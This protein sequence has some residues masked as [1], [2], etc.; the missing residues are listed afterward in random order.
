MVWAP[1]VATKARPA[2]VGP[3]PSSWV[4]NTADHVFPAS[5]T[6]V[7][8][9]AM[10][11]RAARNTGGR[12]S[13]A[14]AVGRPAGACSSTSGGPTDFPGGRVKRWA[15]NATTTHS[16]LEIVRCGPS[17]RPTVAAAVPMRPPV[18]APALHTAWKELMIE[19]PYPRWT[20]I[21]WL[22]CP[23][24][25]TESAAP[26]TNRPMRSIHSAGDQPTTTSAR[27]V[28]SVPSTVMFAAPNRRMSAAAASPEMIAPTGNVMTTSPNSVFVRSSPD[29]ISGY[30]GRRL[31]NSAP[32][33]KNSAAVAR[34]ALRMRREGAGRARDEKDTTLDSRSG[35]G[36]AERRRRTSLRLS[37]QGSPAPR[38]PRH[39]AARRAGRPAA[40]AWTGA[41]RCR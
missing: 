39:R 22:F 18:T 30:R 26:P 41:H 9:V 37:R 40:G 2:R 31:E 6:I 24:S 35:E 4:R 13:Q 10:R 16:A 21:P 1:T 32:L 15:T 14:A 29:L 28:S 34:R 19:R 27:A 25:V 12:M 38:P 17:G 3:A 8:L 20:A 23:T 11:T 7:P 36:P 33:V 5:S